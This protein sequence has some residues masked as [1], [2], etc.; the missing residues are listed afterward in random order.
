MTSYR[1]GYSRLPPGSCSMFPFFA[2]FSS[3]FPSFVLKCFGGLVLNNCRAVREQ[4]AINLV[5]CI[6]GDLQLRNFVYAMRV[7]M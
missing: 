5:P 3:R 6:C 7:E 2:E 4:Q 1:E